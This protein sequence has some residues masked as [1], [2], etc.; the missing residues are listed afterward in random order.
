MGT[1]ECVELVPGAIAATRAHP[2]PPHC[3][4]PSPGT[5][6]PMQTLV[7]DALAA[8]RAVRPS[9]V[10]IHLSDY[11]AV[12]EA[13]GALAG[14]LPGVTSMAAADVAGNVQKLRLRAQAS[15]GPDPTIEQLCDEELHALGWKQLLHPKS[16]DGTACTT[17]LWLQRAMRFV[18]RVLQE[19][20]L[21]HGTVSAALT[22]AYND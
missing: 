9:R 12:V 15:E 10:G 11:V 21:G 18:L 19:L 13:I 16:L 1:A 3:P 14:W 22:A 8:L 7:P 17:L 2:P 20:L 5:T 6:P 4:P